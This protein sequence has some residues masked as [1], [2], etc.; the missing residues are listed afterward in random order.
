MAGPPKT[1]HLSDVR[2]DKEL[3]GYLVRVLVQEDGKGGYEAHSRDLMGIESGTGETEK[4]AMLAIKDNLTKK[5]TELH[6]TY[7]PWVEIVG[8]QRIGAR[9]V[10]CLIQPSVDEPEPASESG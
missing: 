4:Q 1:R 9:V 5:L 6:G 2:W 10:R 7:I 8:Y 3:N